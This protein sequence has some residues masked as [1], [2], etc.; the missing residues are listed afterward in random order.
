MKLG[1]WKKKLIDTR[2]TFEYNLWNKNKLKH[3]IKKY[4]KNQLKKRL[5]K[6]FQNNQKN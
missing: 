5:G 1:I 3:I 4:C 6:I 2:Q